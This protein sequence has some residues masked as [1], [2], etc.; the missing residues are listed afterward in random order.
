MRFLCSIVRFPIGFR[1]NVSHLVEIMTILSAN[2]G[3][4]KRYQPSQ[5]LDFNLGVT[6]S[7]G[8]ISGVTLGI[9]G[10]L[11]VGATATQSNTVLH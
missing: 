1:K 2:I 9:A 11:P 8:R 3:Q 6:F 10:G 7:N 5:I 4:L